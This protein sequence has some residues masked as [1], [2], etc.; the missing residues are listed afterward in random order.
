[1]DEKPDDKWQEYFEFRSLEDMKKDEDLPRKC[2][3]AFLVLTL[4]GLIIFFYVV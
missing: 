2:I 1:M 3:C 4:V